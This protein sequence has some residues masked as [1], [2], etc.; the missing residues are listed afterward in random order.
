MILPLFALANTCIAIGSDWFS[1]LGDSNSLGIIGGLVIGKPLGI[2]MFSVFAVWL[3][4]AVLPQE[5]KW[6][7]ILGAG[8]WEALDLPCPSLLLY[9][10]SATL[11]LLIVRKSLFW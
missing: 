8:S 4:L 10:H 6:K 2:V 5:L 9:S 7:H 3:G 1:N 11:A